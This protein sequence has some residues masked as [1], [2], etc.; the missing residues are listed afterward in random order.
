VQAEPR[1]GAGVARPNP[2]GLSLI[3]TQALGW[4]HAVASKAPLLTLDSAAQAV[5]TALLQAQ[6]ASRT[7]AGPQVLE[8]AT[9]TLSM[10][11]HAHTCKVAVALAY[12][13]AALAAALAVNPTDL[14]LALP[15]LRIHA[16]S[17][18]VGFEEKAVGAFLKVVGVQVEAGSDVYRTL[19]RMMFRHSPGP[20]RPGASGV[21]LGEPAAPG[22]A[23]IVPVSGPAMLAAS[24][25]CGE[26]QGCQYSR[27][28]IATR[29]T[30]PLPSS[31]ALS[32]HDRTLEWSQVEFLP[33]PP[34]NNA[35]TLQ[36]CPGSSY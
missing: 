27:A 32:P 6:F 30:M 3:L 5:S 34:L 26:T 24:E 9:G 29:R 18:R 25:L 12:L 28:C 2:D 33:R 17:T 21:G 10:R 35:P 19:M 8:T 1:P 11:A 13:E 20:G 4:V 23:P 16:T 31:L 14:E 15:C 7:T 36:L 22:P